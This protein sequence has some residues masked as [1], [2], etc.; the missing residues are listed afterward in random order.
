MASL[1]EEAMTASSLPGQEQE[2]LEQLEAL[3]AHLKSSVLGTVWSTLDH[4]SN[5]F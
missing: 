1:A 3:L 4:R 5:T 2:F